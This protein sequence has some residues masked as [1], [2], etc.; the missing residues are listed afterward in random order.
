MVEEDGPPAPPAPKTRKGKAGKKGWGSGKGKG[1][2]KG[3][4]G[5]P[6]AE[7]GAAAEPAA[8]AAHE[9]DRDWVVSDSVNEEQYL[10][11]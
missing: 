2:G 8:E 5:R 1:K 7:W 6:K 11:F 9:P 3:K 10:S 4:G